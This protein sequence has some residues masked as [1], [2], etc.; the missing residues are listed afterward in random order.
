[1]LAGEFD[2]TAALLFAIQTDGTHS[3]L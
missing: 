1:V 3:L 2:D